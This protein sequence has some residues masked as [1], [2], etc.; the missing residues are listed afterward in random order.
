MHRMVFLVAAVFS[1]AT[2]QYVIAQI[3]PATTDAGQIRIL[4]ERLVAAWTAGDIGRLMALYSDDAITMAPN[5][6]AFIGKDAIRAVYAETLRLYTSKFSYQ[7]DEIEVSGDLAFLR[8]TYVDALT[9][10]LGGDGARN[11]GHALTILRREPKGSWKVWREMS[12]IVRARFVDELLR[13]K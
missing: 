11:G 1:L 5:V 9:P 6:P 4:Q 12:T 2:A 10:R 13:K 3:D 8:V 7:V